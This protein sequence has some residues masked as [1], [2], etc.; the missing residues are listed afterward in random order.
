MTANGGLLQAHQYDA[1]GNPKNSS[2][3]RFRFTGQILIPGTELYYYKARVYHPR[4]GRFMQTDPIGY[5]DGMNWYA[6]VGNDPINL[7]DP[8][9]KNSEE[10]NL[11]AN[12]LGFKSSSEA[13]SKINDSMESVRQTVVQALPSREAVHTVANSASLTLAVAAVTT[14][15]TGLC[16]G[17]SLA[18]DTAV[19]VDHLSQGEIKS[20][21]LT[22][23]P[24]ATGEAASV[25]HKTTKAVV[26]VAES[27]K[28][29]AACSGRL[30][31]STILAVVL[32]LT[33]RFSM[34]KDNVELS[35]LTL[36]MTQRAWF[37]SKVIVSLYTILGLDVEG[38]KELLGL[39]L[40]E[41]KGA[42]H[43]LSVLTDLHNRNVQTS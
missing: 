4:L 9:G 35:A 28:R 3:A 5:K 12:M 10:A 8:T 14:P 36:N 34:A 13:T 20:A 24:G 32:P 19:A 40:S 7:A 1:Y 18:I 16:A 30:N 11:W 2:D 23:L 43:W 21:A 22:M 41:S 25:A 27:A 29:G 38:K 17:A 37:L 6:Y 15:C 31:P 26:N 39:Y 42:H 33:K